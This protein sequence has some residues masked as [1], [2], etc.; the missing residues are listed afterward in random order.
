[1][2]DVGGRQ[3]LHLVFGDAQAE[4]VRAGPRHG[5]A[6]DEHRP[7]AQQ[8]PLTEEHGSHATAAGIDDDPLDVPDVAVLCVHVLT[9]EHLVLTWQLIRDGIDGHD[10]C[11]LPGGAWPARTS[12]GPGSRGSVIGPRD[13]RFP[14]VNLVVLV[15]PEEVRRLGGIQLPKLRHGAAK[16]DLASGGIG[17]PSV[18][19]VERDKLAQSLPVRWLDHEVGDRV[20]AGVNDQTPDLAAV[21]VGTANVGP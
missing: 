15:A 21:P 3:V 4:S 9:A 17:N 6:R 12:R 2:L 10:L 14:A 8:V 18:D 1:M 13:H 19:K 11:D 20:I 7:A 16:P 5:R